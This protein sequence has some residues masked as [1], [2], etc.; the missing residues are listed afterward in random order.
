MSDNLD[1]NQYVGRR[2]QEE[3]DKGKKV[4]LNEDEL[5]ALF[6]SAPDISNKTASEYARMRADDME[7]KNA[8]KEE[9]EVEEEVEEE[10]DDDQ[11][12]ETL[13]EIYDQLFDDL[14]VRE[15]FVPVAKK[16]RDETK[17]TVG[18]GHYGDD[19][20]AG[21]EMSED[22]AKEVLAKDIKIHYNR[23]REFFPEFDN[24]PEDLQ[25]ELVSET[26]R[27]LIGKSPKTRKLINEGRFTNAVEEYMDSK[28]YEEVTQEKNLR[29]RIKF[30]LE[31]LNKHGESMGQ[32]PYYYE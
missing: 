25:R 32:T 23:T 14:I 8:P 21:Y 19:Y 4:S 30:L 16:L 22:E 18:Y 20:P 9:E 15:G 11:A 6:S 5:D 28:D 13:I 3:V 17:V 29:P 7:K 26:F 24:Y 2:I 12:Q 31:A 1:I 10:E 27:G